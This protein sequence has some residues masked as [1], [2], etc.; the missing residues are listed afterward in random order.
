MYGY[1]IL[2]E[3]LMENLIAN[4][5]GGISQHAY[6][7]EGAKGIGSLEASKLFAQ[8]LV[9][10]K[11][12][13]TPCTL[14]NSCVMAI[15]DTHPD[16]YYI[17]PLENKAIISVDTIRKVCADAYTK[18]YAS[19]N[20]V[21][22]VTYGDD[23]NDQAQNAF[24]KLLEEPPEYAVF[25]ILAENQMTLLETIRSRCTLVRFPPVADE[26]IKNV[27]QKKYPQSSQDLDFL[28]KY[29]L[30]NLGNAE[31]ILAND[32]FIPLRDLSLEYLP[33]LLSYDLQDAY[34]AAEF[35]EDNKENADT[36]LLFWQKL[37]RDI[38]L[39]Q[40]DSRE[41]VLNSDKIDR[42][43]NLASS[44]DEQRIVRANDSLLLAQKMKRRYVNLR[45]LILALA[46]S[47]K[48]K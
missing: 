29:A 17:K 26:K 34:K 21:Y 16:I 18:P 3:Q 48:K 44:Y 47:I 43:I 41:L 27:L 10:E 35:I 14:C 40:N 42:L 13:I 1:E 15:A 24:L 2:H 31:D 46:F 22:I 12:N 36:V 33:A 23:M 5:R 39:I 19:K 9:C 25:I 38:I 45:T 37:L 7:F 30:G 28:T 4:V 8:T 11:D 32:E 6:I 20:K